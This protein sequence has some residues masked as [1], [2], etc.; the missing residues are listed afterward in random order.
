MLERK[1]YIGY[2]YYS[3]E[4][5]KAQINQEIYDELASKYKV[6]LVPSSVEYD[7]MSEESKSLY[8]IIARTSSNYYRKEFFC[9]KR[10]S[11]LSDEEVLLLLAN[12]S[13]VLGGQ[14]NG[15]YFAVYLD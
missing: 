13:L 9:Y 4:R 8:D 12:G 2:A 10:P 14:C 5:E 11:E 1:I 3:D 6:L 15:N 7:N